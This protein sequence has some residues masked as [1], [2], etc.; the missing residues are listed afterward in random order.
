[1]RSEDRTPLILTLYTGLR[2]VSCQLRTLAALPEAKE[3]PVVFFFYGD[4]LCVPTLRL[5]EGLHVR[6]I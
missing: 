3:L 6:A 2:V 1:M 4:G 5:E